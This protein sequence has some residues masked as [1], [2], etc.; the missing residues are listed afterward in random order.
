MEISKQT[1]DPN[2]DATRKITKFGSGV[3]VT[4]FVSKPAAT[5][6]ENALLTFLPAPVS[7]PARIGCALLKSGLTGVVIG[8][9]VDGA[10]KVVDG[11]FGIGQFADRVYTI[12]TNA[13]NGV[14]EE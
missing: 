12:Y 10:G 13:K 2:V 4:A 5:L 8:A 9:C 1:L 14:A 7:V 3:V 11:I 6:V